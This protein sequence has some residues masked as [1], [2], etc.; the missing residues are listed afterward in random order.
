MTLQRIAQSLGRRSAVGMR[1]KTLG[2][3]ALLLGMLLV[4]SAVLVVASWLS[5][6][7]AEQ[8]EVRNALAGELATAALELAQER[9]LTAAGLT[10]ASLA[11]RL[12]RPSLAEQRRIVDGKLRQV[13]DRLDR[14]PDIVTADVRSELLGTIE[15]VIELRKTVDA[16]LG[17]P[18]DR[19]DASVVAVW[20]PAIS[21]LTELI[22]YAIGEQS[23]PAAAM[24]AELQA[25]L[26]IRMAAFDLRNAAGERSALLWSVIGPSRPVSLAI[27]VQIGSRAEATE[28]HWRRLNRLAAA[29]DDPRLGHA[30]EAARRDYFGRYAAILEQITAAGLSNRPY[31]VAGAEYGH[32][33]GTALRRLDDLVLASQSISTEMLRDRA[34]RA[35]LMLLG[36]VAAVLAGIAVAGFSVV[37]FSHGVL[38]P[39][40]QITGA[41]RRLAAGREPDVLLPTSQRD[42]IGEMS[43]AIAA[44]RDAMVASEIALT[45]AERFAHQTMDALAAYIAVLD[46]AGVILAANKSW[47]EFAETRPG[48]RIAREEENYL[49][50]CDRSAAQGEIDAAAIAEGIRTVIRGE[51]SAFEIEYPCPGPGPDEHSW[52]RMSATPFAGPDKG[53]VRVV[54]A[55]AD[56][57]ERKRAEERLAHL[58][59]ELERRVAEQTAVLRRAQELAGVGHW[60]W[61]RERL[62]GAWHTGLEYSPAAATTFGVTASEL[63]VSDEDYIE[64]FV[65]PDDRA[66]VAGAFRNYVQH[67]RERRPLEYRIVRP[68]GSVRHIRE[69]TETI[70]AEDVPSDPD[71]PAEV[72]GTVQDITERKEAEL[73]LRHSEASLR[74]IFDHAPV[75]MSLRDI[76]G[77][78][79]MINRR[80]RE[81]FGQSE[82]GILGRMPAEFHPERLVDNI[83]RG[84]EHVRRTGTTIVTEEGAATVHGDRRYLTTRFPIL[85]DSGE[86]TGIGSISIDVTAERAAEMALR[87]SEAR[88]RAIYES[89]PDCVALLSRDGR[90][91]E[92]N[93]AGLAMM[94]VDGQP[95]LRG[96]RAEELIVPDHRDHF[97]AMVTAVFA[98]GSG[99]LLFEA[100]GRKGTHRWLAAKAVPM[101]DSVGSVTAMLMIARDVTAQRAVEEQLR[102]VQKMEAIGRLT[103]GVAH[104]FNNLLGVIVG[105]LDLL[106]LKLAGESAEKEL[107]E[108]AVAAAERGAGLIHRLLAFS[109]RQALLP[110]N[111]DA[112]HLLMEMVQLLRRTL[113][114][115]IEVRTKIDPDLMPCYVDPVQL[116]M[117]LLNL[118]LNARD[119]MSG[120][121][122]LTVAACNEMPEPE[123]AGADVPAARRARVVVSV[124]DTGEGMDRDTKARAFEPFF[125]TK[126]VGKGSGLG[127]S[128]VYGF[129]EQSGGHVEIESDVGVGTTVSLHLPAAASPAQTD[130]QE[131]GAGG[132]PG[133]GQLVLVVEDN[134]PVRAFAVDALV[135]LGYRVVEA[136]DG[137]AALAAL[138]A[139]DDIAVL[140]TDVV[141]PGPLDGFALATRIRALRP[142]IR[143][144]YTSGFT[145]RERL[146]SEL[147]GGE[148]ELLLK[149]YRVSE[150]GRRIGR[151]FGK[152]TP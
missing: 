71:D 34:G 64:R 33:T 1:A 140:F 100:S 136:V 62:T 125:T 143:V 101:R 23:T 123:A 19:R 74:A 113:G 30:L 133:A 43:R 79:V 69:T 14:H 21:G 93:P 31:P 104:D 54:V 105:N 137:A 2:G 46:Q 68:D 16:E 132:V 3:L 70:P 22:R 6:R 121:G 20:L 65:H 56:I 112:G 152:E 89:E 67:R 8:A 63:A 36:S 49:A 150:L 73:R 116:E 124:S 4:V 142:G 135:G 80:F 146:P 61:M 148:A 126:A 44:F 37:A 78:Y 40:E 115:R 144:L 95:E 119:S 149:P 38:R 66:A 127:L 7:S 24:D 87:E 98:G 106:S 90:W 84:D 131:P 29:I 53:P 85:D 51:R 52:Y 145:D 15:R 120:G 41:M 45:R 25:V 99:S 9:G 35:K 12:D 47:R 109:R 39:I 5:M 139:H 130:R 50:I 77:R 76:A 138:R 92:V 32:T 97:R 86:L 88:L 60:T 58:N 72:L 96:R 55:H 151:L 147:L 117:A 83:S 110:Q 10:A 57:T 114:E 129:V 59:A 17:K 118:C 18:A 42:E 141:L 28:L 128:M 91:L 48:P 13:R 111:V 134:D 103:G 122:V 107:V 27:A 75:T 26:E 94:E 11:D 102:Q 82:A 81:I 108:R